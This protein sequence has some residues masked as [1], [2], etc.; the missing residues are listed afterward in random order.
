[1]ALTVRKTSEKPSPG[2][3]EQAIMAGFEMNTISTSKYSVSTLYDAIN[4]TLD[5]VSFRIFVL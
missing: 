2:C 4:V 1:M 5:L 3:Y